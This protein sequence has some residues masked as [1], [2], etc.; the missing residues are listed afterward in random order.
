MRRTWNL[1]TALLLVACGD[2]QE[3]APVCPRAPCDIY[4][5]CGCES[6]P[7]H[8]C[9]LDPLALATGGTSCRV[10]TL[11]GDETLVCTRNSSCAARHSCIG[12]RCMRY[13][14]DDEDC[15]GPGGLCVIQP[16]VDDEPI[17]GI[18]GCT[19]DCAPTQVNNPSCPATWACHIYV[20]LSTGADRYL[21]DCAPA[22]A[23]GG[24]VGTACSNQTD[25]AASLDCI[26]L[27]PGNQQC[28]PN[29]ICDDTKCTAGTC[30]AGSG[31]CRE[32]SVPVVIGSSI[33]GVCY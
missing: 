9:D 6:L 15:P 12:G 8:V 11:H 4:A 27:A 17:P 2:F 22:P 31:I 16:T 29:C 10:D 28:R 13:C 33:Y 20:D 18:T 26:T 1:L 23:T 30:P 19:T 25:C 24:G 21:T 3:L 5:Q 32:Y 14:V 7:D